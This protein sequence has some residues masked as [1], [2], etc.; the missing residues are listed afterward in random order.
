MKQK[1]KFKKILK[2]LEVGFEPTT[3][4]LLVDLA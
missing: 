4:A 2:V 3:V 1:K